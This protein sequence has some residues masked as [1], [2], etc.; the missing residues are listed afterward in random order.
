[1]T[2]LKVVRLSSLKIVFRRD[3]QQTLS[4]KTA[5]LWFRC[6]INSTVHAIVNILTQPRG[7]EV[8]KIHVD[9]I[10]SQ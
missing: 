9:C 3:K 1:M 5:N 4:K 10:L 6:C 2:P 8:L 7:L